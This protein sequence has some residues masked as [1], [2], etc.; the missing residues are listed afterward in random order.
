MDYIDIKY[1]NLCIEF[2]GESKMTYKKLDVK[3][4][5]EIRKLSKEEIK[6]KYA[7]D[8]NEKVIKELQEKNLKLKEKYDGKSDSTKG[9]L[10]EMVILTCITKW[11][12][13]DELYIER[14]E[15]DDLTLRGYIRY[16]TKYLIVSLK[17]LL[18]KGY[19][20]IEDF[21]CVT[22]CSDDL[23][24]TK[25]IIYWL[26]RTERNRVIENIKYLNEQII[27]HDKNLKEKEKELKAFENID[28][29]KM[30]T[31]FNDTSFG[32]TRKSVDEFMDSLP[33]RVE[34]E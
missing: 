13:H 18:E 3:D 2:R 25:E 11:G 8:E 31:L 15:G 28:D 30:R 19:V 27:E 20:I 33:R 24:I 6:T 9:K 16:R 34:I 22:T 17:E 10:K 29:K 7:L 1:G 26:L 5:E 14:L 4:I 12:E 32:L 21:Y 23:S